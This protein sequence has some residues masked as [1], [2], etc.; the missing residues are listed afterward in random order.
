MVIEAKRLEKTTVKGLSTAISAGSLRPSSHLRRLSEG[1]RGVSHMRMSHDPTSALPEEHTLQS[2]KPP[3]AKGEL[4]NTVT[5]CGY[6]TRTGT[7]MGVPKRN[8]QDCFSIVPNVAG[9]RGHYVFAVYDG[10]GVYGHSVS[11]MLA[12]RL[13]ELLATH[14]KTKPTGRIYETGIER[15]FGLMQQELI[16]SSVDCS[17]SGSTACVVLVRG[18]S[19]FTANVGDSRAIVGRRVKNS[20]TSRPLSR[21]HKADWPDEHKRIIEAGGR[22]KPC[23]DHHGNALGP[24]RVWLS[25]KNIPGLAMSR[26]FGDLVGSEVGVIASPEIKRYDL[27]ADDKFIVIASDGLWEFMSNQEVVEIVAADFNSAAVELS[28]EKLVKESV[29]RWKRQEETVDDITVV[30]V[31]LTLPA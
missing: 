19:L 2:D 24:Q 5:K 14:V 13:P 28:C 4:V 30:I 1:S 17:L 31:Y 3:P 20:W 25:T 11:G 12:E 27:S 26:S 22:V 23:M 7:S 6:K 10:H 16:R 29:R 9:Q 21:D 18:A 8:N 15:S